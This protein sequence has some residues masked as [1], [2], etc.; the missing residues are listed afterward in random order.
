[1]NNAIFSESNKY[2]I[3]YLSFLL[4]ALF[5]RL[6]YTVSGKKRPRCFF[7]N[8]SYKTRAIVMKFGC[9][10]LNKFA[11]KSCKCFPSHPNNVATLPCE[12]WNAHRARA[13]TEL[14]DKET[15]NLS[16][17]NCPQSSPDLNPVDN[18]VWEILQERCT[19]Y[20]SL[21]CSYQRR[22]WRMAAAMTT[23]SIL[24]LSILSHCFSSSRSVMH[25]F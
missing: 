23:W 20:A 1:M 21:I 11:T 14:L 18:S 17:L 24:A 15:P 4:Y 5:Q 7:C 8:I 22:H 10:F 16:N 2:V 13:T 9:S 12:T 19:K 6:T 25:V 3:T